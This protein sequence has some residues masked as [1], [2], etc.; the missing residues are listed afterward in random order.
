MSERLL[1]WD[2]RLAA[3]ATVAGLIRGFTPSPGTWGLKRRRP[4]TRGLY[5]LHPV[6]VQETGVD[7][8]SLG[9]VEAAEAH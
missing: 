2:V 1:D 9:A 3:L 5:G 4:P 6:T 8:I 7:V